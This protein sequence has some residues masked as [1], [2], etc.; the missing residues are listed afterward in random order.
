MKAVTQDSYG[1]ADVLELRD[2]E[3][4]E[5]KPDEVLIRVHAAGVDQGVR[6][7][8]TGLPW[9]VRPGFGLRR[10]KTP[11]PGLDIA[12]VVEAIGPEVGDFRVGDPVFGTC[13][14][15]S[16]AEYAVARADR[17]A[18]LPP[19]L[20]FEQAAAIPVSAS[21]ALQ[22]LRDHARLRAGQR[23]AIT[24]ASGGVGHF[25]VQL[26]KIFGAAVTG[27]CGPAKQDMV[28]GLGADH[29]IDYTREDFTQ[30]TQ[31]YDV[32]L[33]IAG[34]RPVAQLRR[35][36]APD[37]TLVIV[38]GSGGDRWTGGV[39][40]QAGAMI[41]S[42]F[43]R[44]NLKSFIATAR[45]EDLLFLM[46]LAEAGR[47]APVIDRI[48]PLAETAEAIRRLEAGHARGKSVIAVHRDGQV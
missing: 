43:T 28:R 8:M 45:R 24:G 25:A 34:N 42:P 10:P 2:I 31:R 14:T 41:R 11:V 3:R 19:G 33:D 16:L 40:R 23:V 20:G 36:L 1:S 30:G 17:I 15:G 27:V 12:G 46:G 32:I 5:P 26:A 44:Q 7:R 38:G 6:R 4:P 48:W 37:G 35:A 22:G 13:T 47:F 21:T 9:L 39:H 18:P 29:A